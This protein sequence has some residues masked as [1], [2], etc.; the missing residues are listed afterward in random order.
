MLGL[1]M[2]PN[3]LT[4]SSAERAFDI[5]SRIGVTDVFFLTKGLSGK[6]AFKTA[7]AQPAAEGRDLLAEAVKAAHARGIR[8]HAWF[9]SA[10]DESYCAAHPDSGVHHFSKGTSKTVVSIADPAYARY[11]RT[12]IRDMLERYQIDGVHLD[13]VRYNHLLYGWSDADKERY[14]QRG[15]DVTRA[16]ELVRRTFYGEAADAQAIFEAYRSGDA[17]ASALANARIMDVTAF[18]STLLEGIREMRPDLCLSAALMPEGAYDT[19]FANLHYGQ[20]YRELS[21]FFD[22]ILPMAYSGAYGKDESW[23]KTAAQGA[24]AYGAAVL[25]GLQAYDGGTGVTLKKDMEAA[26]SVKGTS[27]VCLF[28]YGAFLAAIMQGEMLTLMNLLEK[29][30][31]HIELSNETQTKRLEKTVAPGESIRIELPF[32]ANSVRGW[33]DEQE[34]CVFTVKTHEMPLKDKKDT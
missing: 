8:L 19:V 4:G 15:V 1:W 3:S 30:V 11:V 16:C 10:Q 33:S 6:C 7:L 13:Y 20:S 26:Q 32:N 14:R 27:G 9:T 21:K 31:T 17:T 5:C 28:R 18:A 12:I 24:A 29:P 22:A 25:T 23:V 34:D 2:W